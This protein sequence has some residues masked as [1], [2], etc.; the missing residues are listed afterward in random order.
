MSVLFS[1]ILALPTYHQLFN[2]LY[3]S[4][5]AIFSFY[6]TSSRT[7]RLFQSTLLYNCRGVNARMFPFSS[8]GL[9]VISRAI[10]TELVKKPTVSH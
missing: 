4:L 5:N 10:E 7:G 3:L 2:V 6:F 9:C 1:Y 8:M